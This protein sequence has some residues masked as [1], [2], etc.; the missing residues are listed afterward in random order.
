MVATKTV[1]LESFKELNDWAKEHNMPKEEMDKRAV[2]ICLDCK[3]YPRC[4][5]LRNKDWCYIAAS[6]A[7]VEWAQETLDTELVRAGGTI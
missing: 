4:A 5:N 2:K 1:E 3:D 6:A 7:I